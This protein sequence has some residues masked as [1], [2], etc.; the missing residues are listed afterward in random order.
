MRKET[1]GEDVIV[2]VV[3]RGARQANIVRD[4][5]DRW[6]FLR[7]IKYLNDESVPRNW[8]R[9]IAPKHIREGFM[10]PDE[11]GEP[12]PYVSILAY[13]LMDNHFHILLQERTEDGIARF[14]Q[15]VCT[16]MAAY[17]NTKYNEK[18][19]LFQGPYKARV[20]ESDEHLQ[21][22]SAYIQIKN[23]LERYP[24]GFQNAIRNYDEA[25]KWAQLD[26]FNSLA[27]YLRLRERS[28]IDLEAVDEVF[29]EEDV[30]S[31]GRDL[32]EGKYLRNEDFRGLE[33]D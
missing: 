19:S 12:T 29:G 11:W 6:R 3:Q 9:E 21:Y 27:D 1:F 33:L 26:P 25:L 7:L 2:H 15:R 8:E 24:G 16:S 30:I 13:C 23:P 20:V 18:G 10:R 31:F 5:S 14:M 17:F 22:L 28:L 4:D 32:L